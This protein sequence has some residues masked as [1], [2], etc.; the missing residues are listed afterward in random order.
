MMYADTT[1]H[2][3]V[4][5][6]RCSQVSCV[7]DFISLLAVLDLSFKEIHALKVHWWNIQG[8]NVKSTTGITSCLGPWALDVSKHRQLG[9]TLQPHLAHSTHI[10]ICTE[11]AS[12]A[13]RI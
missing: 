1:I 2:N 6:L 4:P 9:P 3:L 10:S 13:F 12:L 5:F 11:L 8:T 7:S